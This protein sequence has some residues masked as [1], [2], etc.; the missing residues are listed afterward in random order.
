MNHAR[1]SNS[2]WA[3]ARPDRRRTDSLAANVN[4]ALRF[5]TWLTFTASSGS[6]GAASVR[7]RGWLAVGP[8]GRALRVERA[9]AVPG[10][11]RAEGPACAT[12]LV[13]L[14]CEGWLPREPCS[15]PGSHPKIGRRPARWPGCP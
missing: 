8:L 9:G 2:D 4:Q 5:A 1:W 13:R 6:Y 7:R 15:S 3:R 11:A 10:A 12:D 14:I